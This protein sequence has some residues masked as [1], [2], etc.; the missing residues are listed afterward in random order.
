MGLKKFRTKI[1][2]P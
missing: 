2:A 1:P